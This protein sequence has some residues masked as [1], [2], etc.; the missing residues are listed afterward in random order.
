MDSWTARQPG[1]LLLE[2][3]WAKVAPV[4][5][6]LNNA[7]A[8]FEVVEREPPGHDR[9]DGLLPTSMLRQL[10]SIPHRGS[11]ESA[12]LS[13][14]LNRFL[15][16]CLCRLAWQFKGAVPYGVSLSLGQLH[17]PFLARPQAWTKGCSSIC[18]AAPSES[19][20]KQYYVPIVSAASFLM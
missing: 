15:L 1:A 17:L 7:F 6:A 20:F 4:T 19:S 11:S 12:S 8:D 10:L 13:F 2:A 14:F 5:E 3:F 16:W 18:R 9:G